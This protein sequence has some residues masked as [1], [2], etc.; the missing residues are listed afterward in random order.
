MNRVQRLGLTLSMMVLPWLLL[1]ST[2]ASAGTNTM[3]V[4]QGYCGVAKSSPLYFLINNNPQH[5]V[6][7][8]V[9]T[10]WK[11]GIDSGQNDRVHVLP[12]GGR[13]SLGCG[14]SGNIPTSFYQFQV[15]GEEELH[16]HR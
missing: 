14:D 12:P 1:Q 9:R 15:V 4:A 2:M 13:M 3:I 5:S 7:V 8:T 16:H 10:F 6:R 11:S